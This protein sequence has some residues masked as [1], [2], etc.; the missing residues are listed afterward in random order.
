VPYF[1][2]PPLEG[3]EVP[4]FPAIF[5]FVSFIVLYIGNPLGSLLWF[6]FHGAIDLTHTTVIN[7]ICG[8]VLIAVGAYTAWHALK[9]PLAGSSLIFLSFAIFSVACAVITARGRAHGDYP[10]VGANSS[11]YSIFAAILLFGLIFY[12]AP[13]LTGRWTKSTVGLFIVLC[14]VSYYNGATVYKMA[15]DQNV[16]LAAAYAPRAAASEFD[17]RMYPEGHEGYFSSLKAELFRIGIGPYRLSKETVRPLAGPDY[18]VALPLVAGSVVKQSFPVAQPEVRSIS[19]QVAT[20]AR[21]QWPYNIHWR[22]TGSKSQTVFG[23]GSFSAFAK[24]DW[25]VVTIRPHRSVDDAEAELTLSVDRG[26]KI[27][28]PLGLAI[29]RGLDPSEP[30]VINGVTRTDEGKIGLSIAYA[31]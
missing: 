31:N 14:A 15:R 26:A 30:A 19:F 24:E 16:W 20:W 18:I 27:I 4:V 12:Y 1:Q 7:A 22:L 8:V 5:D 6:P 13:R 10:I 2:G 25:G 17:E 3:D 21:F 23:E 28:N 29:Y 11:R 9:K